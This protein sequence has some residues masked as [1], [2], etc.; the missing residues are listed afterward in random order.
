MQGNVELT[1]MLLEATDRE[2]EGLMAMATQ[3][4][5]VAMLELLIGYGMAADAD[6]F[7]FAAGSDRDVR[8]LQT[9]SSRFAW[10]TRIKDEALVEAACIGHGSVVLQL[11]AM[12]ASPNAFGKMAALH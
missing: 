11:L 3:H 9:L 8:I 12:S 1:G 10:P 2:E 6:D 7:L 4:G 5:H